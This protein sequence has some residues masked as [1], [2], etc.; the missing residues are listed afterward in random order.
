[1]EH[2]NSHSIL[3]CNI[4]PITLYASRS[5]WQAKRCIDEVLSN[6]WRAQL[7]KEE[8]LQFPMYLSLQSCQHIQLTTKNMSAQGCTTQSILLTWLALS[9]PAEQCIC[10]VSQQNHL[11]ESAFLRTSWCTQWSD[12]YHHSRWHNTSNGSYLLDGLDGRCYRDSPWREP[13]FEVLCGIE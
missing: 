1:M 7:S 6:C 3:Q 2:A 4:S 9:A 5:L 10:L 13:N 8:S 12:S 11:S